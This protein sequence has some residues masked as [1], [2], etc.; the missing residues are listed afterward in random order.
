VSV[1]EI[2]F[3]IDK[4]PEGHLQLSINGD[5]GGYRISG[6]KYDGRSKTIK[7]HI[8]TPRDVEEIRSYLALVGK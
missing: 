3:S 5:G 6:P 1:A 2:Y 7:Q 4:T 8:L